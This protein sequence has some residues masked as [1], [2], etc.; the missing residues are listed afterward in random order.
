MKS[1]ELKIL[2]SLGI[3]SI[4][5]WMTFLATAFMTQEFFGSGAMAYNFLIQS[6]PS[7]FL[8][9]VLGHYIHSQNCKKIYIFSQILLALNVLVLGISV[10]KY[11]VYFFLIIAA[12]LNAVAIPCLQELIKQVVPNE[13]SKQF[14]SQFA[15]VNGAMLSLSTGLGGFLADQL[16]YRF[17]FFLDASSYFIAG[18]IILN[19]FIPSE[20]TTIQAINRVSNIRTYFSKL[21]I[22][23]QTPPD[24]SRILNIWFVF[25]LMG[26]FI[27][28]IEFPIFSS[29][30]FSKTEV[31]QLIGA[32]GFGQLVCLIWGQRF[33]SISIKNQLLILIFAL[34][35]F[36]FSKYIIISQICFFI[37]GYLTATISGFIRSEILSHIP[38][39]LTTA[40][41]SSYIQSRLGMINI[42]S[43]L[44]LANLVS[45]MAHWMICVAWLC[46]GIIMHHLIQKQRAHEGP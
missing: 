8:A 14:Q 23:L 3:N 1:I 44:L 43:Y 27:N 19:I 45:V 25:L 41:V 13:N 22:R 4:G 34:G 5:T 17:L 18:M 32:W 39:G 31:G 20:S 36:I 9:P 10:W 37:A 6:L 40:Q 33:L 29:H 42:A 35:T 21:F 2:F 11:H 7:I 24:L 28:A 46:L 30:Q 38:Q 16:G 26:A 12:S 15:A